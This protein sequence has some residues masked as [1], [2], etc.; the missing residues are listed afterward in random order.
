MNV[1]PELL[2]NTS[3]SS[4]EGAGG[5]ARRIGDGL[6]VPSASPPGHQLPRHGATHLQPR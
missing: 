2:I 4:S 3:N 1:R 5:F 6:S